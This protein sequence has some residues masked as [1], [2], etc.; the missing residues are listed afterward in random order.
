MA[1]PQHEAHLT[2]RGPG[3]ENT[4]HDLREGITTFGRLPSNDIILLGDLVSRHHSRIT[5]FEGQATLQ[6]LGSHNGSFVNGERITTQVLKPGDTAR[7]GNF[8]VVFRMGPAP[9]YNPVNDN[10]ASFNHHR[11]APAVTLPPDGLALPTSQSVL[12]NDLH[13]ARSSKD[14]SARVLRFV[15]RSADA[16]ASA[17]DLPSYMEEMLTLALE[18]TEAQI[19]VYLQAHGGQ[20]PQVIVARNLDGPVQRPHV[21]MSVVNWVVTKAFGIKSA[22]LSDDIRFAGDPSRVAGA[23]S[24]LCVPLGPEGEANGAIYLSRSAPAFSDA[25]LDALS[26]VAHLVNSGINRW[27]NKGNG[28]TNL[29]RIYSEGAAGQ[30][31]ARLQDA[32]GGLQPIDAAVLRAGLVGAGSAASHSRNRIEHTHFYDAWCETVLSVLTPLGAETSFGPG[33][34]FCAVFGPGPESPGLR[35]VQAALDLKTATEALVARHGEV[36]GCQLRAGIDQGRVLVGAIGGPNRVAWTAL[37]DPVDIAA[38]LQAAGPPG[39]ILVTDR[40]HRLCG[41]HFQMRARGEQRIRGYA[42]PV[43]LHQ[44]VASLHIV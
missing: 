13:E 20:E 11:D 15:L 36:G 35:A 24:V 34:D 2:V 16:L 4:L 19:G 10:T 30:M 44:I 40:L 37:G 32:A 18:Q 28:T 8:Q 17:S 1:E 39:T 29:S 25:E 21:A 9:R 42:E 41:P 22:N 26:A 33:A 12:L 6:D 7:V 3:H 14:P 43:L 27:S 38:R 31:Q 5:Y 23:L